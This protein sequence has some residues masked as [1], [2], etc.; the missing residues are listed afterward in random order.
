MEL[1][2][3]Q[4]KKMDKPTPQIRYEVLVLQIEEN[5]GLDLSSDFS[6]KNAGSSDSNGYSGNLGGLASLSFDVVHQFGYQFAVDLSLSLSQKRSRVLADTTMYGLSGEQ[7]R[8]QNTNTSRHPTTQIDADTGEKEVTGFR[9]ITSGLI[10]EVKGWVSG[11]NMVTM[12]VKTTISNETSGSES[13]AETIPTTTEKVVN[14]HVRSPSGEPL[15]LSGLKQRDT[16]EDIK[17]VPGL[18]D[19]PLLGLL[20]QRRVESLRN[21]E[22]LIT[23]IPY[24]GEEDRVAEN[25]YTALYNRFCQR[26]P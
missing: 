15:V 13:D 4:L 5:Q 14:T 1:L 9:E 8:F 23:L 10:V 25:P 2:Q 18:G 12:D 19:I 20:F 7:I 11:D 16:V 22:F 24:V 6:I 26:N 21:T 17:K 3:K